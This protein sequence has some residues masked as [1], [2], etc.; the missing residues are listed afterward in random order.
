MVDIRPRPSRI[1]H[2]F[3]KTSEELQKDI[4][5][6]KEFIATLEKLNSK[7]V[8]LTDNGYNRLLQELPLLEEELKKRKE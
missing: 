1:P 7:E 4:E 2:P 3:D 8:L 6:T 5:L